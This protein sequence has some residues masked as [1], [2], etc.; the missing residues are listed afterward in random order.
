MKV[1][2]KL[3]GQFRYIAGVKVLEIEAKGDT[4]GDVL[5]ALAQAHPE[6]GRAA[7]SEGDLRPYVSMMVNG[8]SVKE[9][10]GLATR[11][12]ENDDIIL[13]PPMAGG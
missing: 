12:N 13:F 10:G 1:R 2:V 8:K 6:L 9:T 11:V 4:A 5:T 7:M 3:F